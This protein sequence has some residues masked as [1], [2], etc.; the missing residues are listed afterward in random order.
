MRLRRKDGSDAKNIN[1]FCR[2]GV[3]DV[4]ETRI[5]VIPSEASVSKSRAWAILRVTNR[6]GR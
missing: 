5:V 3:L 6:R 2:D 4:P 1:I